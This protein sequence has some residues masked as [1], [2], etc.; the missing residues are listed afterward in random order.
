MTGTALERHRPPR[1]ERLSS[2]QL[3]FIV[4]SELVPRTYRGK[5]ADLFACVL[6][7]RQLGIGDMHALRSI[8]VVDGKASIS[9]ELMVT[10][11]R[12]RGHSITAD[13]GEG[14]VTVKGKRADNGD[15]M[16]VTWTKS[17]AE[18]AGLAGKDN[19]KRYPEAMLW[20]RAVS[21]LCRMLFPDVLSGMS[22]T[23][24]EVEL[25]AEERVSEAV[26]RVAVPADAS[27]PDDGPIVE[28]EAVEVGAGMDDEGQQ[29]LF[30]A[31]REHA[32]EPRSGMPA[33]DVPFGEDS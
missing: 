3:Q 24:D 11:T 31:M 23:P 19:W 18:R 8:Y 10:L 21:Q 25:T 12:Q 1:P 28:G 9:A 33:D 32:T 20:A 26:G 6:L 27:V 5:P 22:Y 29:D 16:S 14:R 17:M 4:N 30:D 2:E 13:Y 15:E 7:G